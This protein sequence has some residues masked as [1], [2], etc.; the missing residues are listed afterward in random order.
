MDPGF[1]K[2]AGQ[3][4]AQGRSHTSASDIFSV[5]GADW[6]QVISPYR[7][8]IEAAIA[9]G[10]RALLLT[11]DGVLGIYLEGS[12]Q[13]RVQLGVERLKPGLWEEH[14]AKLFAQVG[15]LNEVMPEAERSL[16]PEELRKA[17]I[18]I[19][20]LPGNA[21]LHC[22]VH[23][24]P[25]AT[26][27]LVSLREQLLASIVFNPVHK[28]LLEFKLDPIPLLLHEEN[29]AQSVSHPLGKNISDAAPGI[30]RLAKEELCR[31]LVFID[32]SETFGSQLRR[33]VMR[34][35]PH[36][37]DLGYNKLVL[38]IPE[39]DELLLSSALKDGN[40]LDYY[41]GRSNTT[42]SDISPEWT[43][44][45][46]LAY[47]LSITI[48]GGAAKVEHS[49]S[50]AELQ[51]SNSKSRAIIWLPYRRAYEASKWLELLH[52]TW[53][54]H[55]GKCIAPLRA[56]Q[57]AEQSNIAQ[58]AINKPI[59]VPLKYLMENTP[60]GHPIPALA[61]QTMTEDTYLF[62][63]LDTPRPPETIS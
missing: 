36:F 4:E 58:D 17:L 24:F 19:F 22:A 62:V 3:L 20:G 51:G 27:C 25:G 16:E 38:D 59:L 40:P 21:E 34:L 30:L 10:Y 35:L 31:A 23:S 12:L 32:G 46:S 39:E 13:L 28:F 14:V 45:L 56:S 53:G 7:R 8:I 9:R 37:V 43:A 63:S 57:L 2:N 1:L 5:V 41:L 18:T 60:S 11:H 52:Q 33:T 26:Q 48:S 44:L 49:K 55:S 29:P 15:L 42:T 61:D 54:L 6:Q 47:S 50:F